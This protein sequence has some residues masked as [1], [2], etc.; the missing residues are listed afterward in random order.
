LF[1]LRNFFLVRLYV[2][3]GVLIVQ[4]LD[5][6][7][8][9]NNRRS[10]APIFLEASMPLSRQLRSAFFVLVCTTPVIAC[11]T[12]EMT[13]ISISHLDGAWVKNVSSHLVSCLPSALPS[14]LATDSTQY[15]SM[16]SPV[17]SSIVHFQV[18]QDGTTIRM[19]PLAPNGREDSLLAMSGTIDLTDGISATRGTA[20][21]RTEGPRGGG[22]TFTVAESMSDTSDFLVSINSANGTIS[23]ATVLSFGSRTYA[24]RDGGATGPVFTTCT[25]ANSASGSTIGR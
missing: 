18:A 17:A 16:P 9:Q 21:V 24:F 1:D 23:G 22:H 3:D 10:T 2:V 19:V 13:G 12:S 11:S 7:T 4:C 20:P 8:V 15:V 6:V 14:A 5:R 25:V